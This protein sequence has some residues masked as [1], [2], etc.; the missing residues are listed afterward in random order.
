MPSRALVVDDEPAVCDF[1][2]GVLISTGMEV[3]TLTSSQDA[4]L[5]LREEK[6]AVALLDFRMPA[7]SGIDLA[8]QMR[9]S[10]INLMTPII[11]M[12]DDQS[13]S[14]VSE[15]FAAG[16]SFFL[17]KPIDRTRLLRLVRSSQGAIEHERRRF[18]RV[19][20]RCKVRIG[21]DKD[22]WECHT[23]DVSLNG[24]LIEGTR[25]VPVGTSVRVS[26]ELSPQMRPIVGSGYVVRALGAGRLGIQLNQMTAAET[27]RLQEFLLP[28][29]L[30]DAREAHSVKGPRTSDSR[31]FSPKLLSG[32][33]SDASRR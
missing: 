21:I 28:L 13:T 25:T 11:F 31:I 20:M 8:Q 9:R 27:S 17:Y 19:T 10:G 24:M 4:A 26:L 32:V 18:S 15:G 2:R 3:L 16:A 22:E 14:A 12:S 7:P 1:I 23:V 30:R 5:R 29:V 6:F 33:I